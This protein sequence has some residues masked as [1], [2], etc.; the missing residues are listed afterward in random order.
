MLEFIHAGVR[1]MLAEIILFVPADANMEF[2][3]MIFKYDGNN[4]TLTHR[5][6]T[7]PEVTTYSTGLG[8]Y[9]TAESAQLAIAKY[10]L[11]NFGQLTT[12][13]KEFENSN[14]SDFL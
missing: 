13:A 10:L 8:S 14:I 2:M 11:R 1:T 12:T 3:N 9:S 4:L 6:V 5:L 7:G